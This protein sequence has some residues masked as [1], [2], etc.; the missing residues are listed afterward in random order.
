MA[1]RV[2]LVRH[3]DEPNDDR[4]VTWLAAYG[5]EAVTRKPFSG[6]RLDNVGEVAASVIYG[7]LFDVFETY[8]ALR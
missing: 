7:G 1:P 4:V 5:Y 3:G 6:D 2:L 8:F